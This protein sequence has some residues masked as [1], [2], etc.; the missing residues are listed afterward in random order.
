MTLIAAEPRTRALRV[1]R[2]GRMAYGD[3]MRWQRRMAAEA[4]AGGDEAVAL[5]EHEPVYTLGRRGTAPP[6]ALPAPVAA[7]DRGG[8]ITFHGPGQAV[9][10]PVVRLRER[11]IRAGE[12]VRLIERCAIKT[13]AA[14]GVP[15][16][17][18]RG[19]PGAWA[20][21]RKLASVGV[22][23]SG[24]VSTHGT[25]LNVSTDLTWFDWIDACGLPG[26]QMTSLQA[27]TGRE[28]STAEAGEAM[29][30]ALIDALAGRPG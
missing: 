25:A 29:A 20:G 13:A 17:R 4:A 23:V 9:M 10:Y 22:R 14:A 7:S 2:L 26:V 1:V 24:G 6:V 19:R 16:E 30:A 8:R 11:G 12:W 21:G 15:A 3:A 27:E 28:C 18:R 5:V